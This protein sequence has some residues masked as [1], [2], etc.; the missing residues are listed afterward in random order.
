MIRVQDNKFVWDW[1]QLSGGPAD[2]FRLFIGTTPADR[3]TAFNIPNPAARSVN[4]ADVGTFQPGVTYFVV[5]VAFNNSGISPESNQISFEVLAEV[6]V[7][8]T[9]L[10]IE[11]I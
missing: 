7:A 3:S 5:I 6:P 8:P 1:A 9:N 10:R 4:I 11:L 2:G